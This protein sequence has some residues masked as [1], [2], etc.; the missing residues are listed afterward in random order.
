MP[1]SKDAAVEL[2]R[3]TDNPAADQLLMAMLKTDDPAAQLQAIEVTL[4]RGYAPGMVKIVARLSQL[5][6]D[7]MATVIGRA[8][9]LSPALRKTIRD[10]RTE[11]R[12]NSVEIIR[13]SCDPSLAYLLSI[14]LRDGHAGIRRAAADGLET[15]VRGLLHDEVQLREDGSAIHWRVRRE[16]RRRICDALAD[17][18]DAF[19]VH[20][21]RGVIKAAMLLADPD[22]KPLWLCLERHHDARSDIVLE[23]LAGG[24]DGDMV[25]FFYQTLALG[26][27]RGRLLTVLTT[28]LPGPRF[29]CFLSRGYLLAMPKVAESIGRLRSMRVLDG[30]LDWLAGLPRAGRG[31]LA[32]F[33]LTSGLSTDLKL[34]VLTALSESGDASERLDALVGALSMADGSGEPLIHALLTDPDE[35]VQ[36]FATR[37]IVYRKCA[38]AQQLL[39]SQ[40]NSEFESVRQLA[41]RRLAM[42]TFEYYWDAFERLDEPRQLAAGRALRKLDGALEDRLRTRLAGDD[43]DQQIRA[44]RILRLLGL[45]AG[46]A[47]QLMRLSQEGSSKV[48]A[49]AVRLLGKVHNPDAIETTGKALADVDVRVQA[50]AVESLEEQGDKQLAE[51]VRPMLASADN[52]IVANAAKALAASLTEAL[53]AIE[54]LLAD[55][56]V[57]Y[58]LSG[59]WVMG[60]LH[61]PQLFSE[62][63]RICRMDKNHRVRNRAIE[64]LTEIRNSLT[65]ENS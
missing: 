43:P 37:G 16:A 57:E 64:I 58:R 63:V 35:D 27:H 54:R 55:K 47:R 61:L 40:L 49:T 32:R 9:D 60:Q 2:L 19:H 12:V 31:H 17:A 18:L 45:E 24:D 25:D 10:N 44:M 48:R 38:N 23:L 56:R 14:A 5:R 1:Q 15:Y 62:I 21:E 41:T 26:H 59:L 53:P 20:G 52:R 6:A 65:Q 28:C 33:V 30:P 3:Q 36:R 34:G 4:D 50:N 39:L 8:R 7:V 46:C 29:N 51:K 11:L 42:F 22:C 13:R